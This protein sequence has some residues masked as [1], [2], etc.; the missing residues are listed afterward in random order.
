MGAFYE[1]TVVA[2][3]SQSE[4]TGEFEAAALY[5]E[6]RRAYN[7]RVAAVVEDS[8]LEIGAPRWRKA[9][10]RAASF[11][12]SDT[13][14]ST[15]APHLGSRTIL[16]IVI[17]TRSSALVHTH[18]ESNKRRGEAKTKTKD[19]LGLFTPAHAPRVFDGHRTRLRANRPNV[20]RRTASERDAR[21]RHGPS[22]K[23][24]CLS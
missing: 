24:R 7:K 18:T 6:N 15:R 23:G 3:R 1:H 12:T 8:W 17:I 21:R 13:F 20:A 14:E 22:F 5:N 16:F 9:I 4:F 2:L 10:V 19:A 11:E